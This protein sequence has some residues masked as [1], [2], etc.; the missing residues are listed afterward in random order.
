MTATLYRKT[1]SGKVSPFWRNGWTGWP[2]YVV[3]AQSLA[4]LILEKKDLLE[5]SDF[6]QQTGEPAWK[7][8]VA[9]EIAAVTR[10][11]YDSAVR[12]LYSILK[13]EQHIANAA[14]AEGTCLAF[15]LR[16]DETDIPTLPGNLA[17]AVN[18]IEVRS[19]STDDLMIR[20]EAKVALRLSALI[21]AYPHNQKRLQDLA[22]YNCLRPYR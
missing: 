11:S 16:L 13:G 17:T 20:R 8:H 10:Q 19:E 4:R 12:R 15:G 2:G 3:P 21:L 9:A 22:P 5:V 7:C 14:F 6:D 18:L 1:P